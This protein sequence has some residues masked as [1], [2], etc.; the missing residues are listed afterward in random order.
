M[1]FH[2]RKVQKNSKTTPFLSLTIIILDISL[3]SSCS[4]ARILNFILAVTCEIELYAELYSVVGRAVKRMSLTMRL[5]LWVYIGKISQKRCIPPL[6]VSEWTNLDSVLREHWHY[7]QVLQI[8]YTLLLVHVGQWFPTPGP[9]TGADP[10][11]P[12]LEYFFF[13]CLSLRLRHCIAVAAFVGIR[14]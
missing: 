11:E 9:R 13:S 7:I 1:L 4:A 3:Q 5:L 14:L 6:T 8:D 12:A 2:Y 10:L